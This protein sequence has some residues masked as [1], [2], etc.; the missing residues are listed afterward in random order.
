M[1]R[2]RALEMPFTKAARCKL[3]EAIEANMKEL[4][5]GG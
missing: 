1:R 3:D 4:G 2:G 5:F